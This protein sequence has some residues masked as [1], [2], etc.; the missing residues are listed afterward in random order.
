MPLTV[1][2]ANA[3]LSDPKYQTPNG[4]LDLVRQLSVSTAA[5]RPGVTTLLY[6]GRLGPG[7]TGPRAGELADYIKE[8]YSS[9]V[10]VVDSTPAAEFLKGGAFQ[11]AMGKAFPTIA[12][13]DAWLYDATK[14]P[15]AVVSQNFVEAAQGPVVSITPFADPARTF[16][17]VEIATT[18]E[19]P[20]V[21]SIEGLSR[22]QLVEFR[23]TLI[24]RGLSPSD[25]NSRVTELVS[26]NSRMA[27]ENLP[28]ATEGGKIT[29]ADLSRYTGESPKAIPSG[30]T[31]SILGEIAG[32]PTADYMASI[33]NLS[34]SFEEVGL[35]AKYWGYVEG[36]GNL[37]GTV[38]GLM[39]AASFASMAYDAYN[40][41]QS[42]DTAGALTL[43]RDWSLGSAGALL[44]GGLAF[45]GSAALF[46]PLA[47]LGPIGIGVAGVGI[48]GSTLL[49]SYLGHEGGVGLG[50]LITNLLSSFNTAEVTRSP[51]ILDLDGDGVETIG[52]SA[53]IHFD[54]D[55]NK[56]AETTGWVGKDDGLLVWDKNGNGSIDNGSEL[57]GN[58]TTLGAGGKAS[59]GF[60][61][62]A[63]LDSNHDSK[64]DAADA[65]FAQ[66]RVW[67]DG[68]SDGFVQAGELLSLTDA[69]VKSLNTAYTEPGVV[70]ANGD[71]PASVIDANGNQ[72]RQVGS[73]TRLNGT[74][75][76][77]ED[78]WFKADTARTVDQNLIAV[79]ATIAA[80]PEVEGFGNVHSLQQAMARDTSG[81][82]Q[83]LVTQFGQTTD[84]QVRQGLMNELLYRWAGVQDVDPNSRAATQ[85]YGNAIGD[86]RKLATLEAFLGQG[87]LGTWCWGTRDPNPH[88]QAAPILLRAF[89]LLSSYVYSQLMLQTQYKPLLESIKVNISDSA[90]TIDV[91]QIV[92]TLRAKYNTNSDQGA[93]YLGDFATSLKTIGTLGTEVIS[94]LRKLGNVNATGFDSLLATLGFNSLTGTV[95]NDYLTGSASD[96]VIDG[97]AGN[98]NI[99]AGD[100][101]N[102]VKA[103]LGNDIIT[104]GVGNDL[105]DGGD[106]NDLIEGGTGTNTLLGGAGNDMIS[107]AGILTGGTGNDVLTGYNGT[108]DTFVFNVGDGADTISTYESSGVPSDVLKFGAGI[109][110]ASLKLERTG[111]DLIFKIGSNGDQV[112]VSNW[113]YGAYYQL[114]KLQF[115]DATVLT[116]AQISQLSVSQTGTA[117]NDYLYGSA[118]ND[119]IDGLDG[120]DNISAGD[121]NNT[122]K[123]GLGDDYITA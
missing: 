72:H 39:M 64:V 33:K 113:Y 123:G 18:L 4:L 9:S 110:A 112:R 35:N 78:V 44:A 1:A 8:N 31:S 116:N 108:T 119:V 68:N 62:L 50:N 83:S 91:S 13:R 85:I 117:A 40:A 104:A 89:D 37:L 54:H 29:W 65:A 63:D 34:A 114:A 12:A 28:I 45:E 121:G 2:Q 48:I 43:V 14:G 20:N 21:P 106:G 23:D 52:T 107:G 100:G 118:S 10:R 6:S 5:D 82:L 27:T 101:N 81:K 92:A 102:S 79:S 26:F 122:V 47:L 57:F 87:Y 7:D 41:Y 109:T 16:G 58:S 22:Q 120:N 59:N 24:S 67:K 97:L 88:G 95:G 42:G 86:A 61:A 105:I 60:N 25:A 103:G 115:A 75:A 17:A 70:D 46:A 53:G 98:D 32:K 76:K 90:V 69:G 93:V 96:D 51:L 49:A 55:G 30:A 36:A 77:M 94:N 99:S 66:L 15:W 38:G 11:T 73:Y 111:S 19:N 3:L 74:T 84:A 80:L 56:F 71:V